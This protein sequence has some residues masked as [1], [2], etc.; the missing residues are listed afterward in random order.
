M[1][2]DMGKKENVNTGTLLKKI[3][4]IG[5]RFFIICWPFITLYI[6][7]ASGIKKELSQTDILFFL[8][9]FLGGIEMI[10]YLSN[11]AKEVREQNISA[12]ER[13]LLDE[14]HSD[15][16]KAENVVCESGNT[17]YVYYDKEN[18]A[19]NLP[20]FNEENTNKISVDDI[21]IIKKQEKKDIIAL[22]LKNNDEITEYFT[23]SKKQAKSSYRFS[24]IAA[25][26]GMFMLAFAAYGAI[27]VGSV[28]LIIIGVIGGA[29]TELVA[30]VVLWIH[31]K[32]AMQL[33]YYYDALHENER[34]L[35]AINMADKLDEQK[36][37]DI[38]VEIIRKQIE[39]HSS[40]KNKD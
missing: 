24:V 27:V 6:S 38:Y 7:F 2:E 37:E 23:I 28:D 14:L 12:Y 29:I 15:T 9:T 19:E 36:R 35:A 20:H 17:I 31:N 25:V 1:K 21:K 11:E 40:E 5:K 3:V 16:K 26:I 32:S 34:F 8:I 39:I 10:F 22:M 33:N 18:E 4:P 13:Y 30:G